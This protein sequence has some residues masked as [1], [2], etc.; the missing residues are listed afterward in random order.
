MQ[1]GNLDGDELYSKAKQIIVAGMGK[2]T[3]ARLLGIKTQSA[4]C[5]LE[6]WRGETQGDS[7]DAVYRKVQRLKQTHPEL[8]PRSIARTLG[9]SIYR[10]KL[11]L[12][13]YRGATDYP[14][15][16]MPAQAAVDVPSSSQ[17]SVPEITRHTMDP[18]SA[19]TV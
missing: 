1:N 11:W 18:I 4:S 12:A 2:R 17:C 6:R 15:P 9:I 7:G 19:K 13:R 14:P 10:T 8:G 5:L 3:L 16:A